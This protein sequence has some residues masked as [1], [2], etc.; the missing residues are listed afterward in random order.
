MLWPEAHLW[1]LCTQKS[2]SFQSCSEQ[3]DEHLNS[4]NVGNFLTGLQFFFS[5]KIIMEFDL[6]VNLKLYNERVLTV[7]LCKTPFF[8]PK[9]KS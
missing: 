6:I 1:N 3:G 5:G 9:S 7:F 2:T 4:I 8:F